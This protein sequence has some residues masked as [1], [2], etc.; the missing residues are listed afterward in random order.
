MGLPK[1]HKYHKWDWKPRHSVQFG[2]GTTLHNFSFHQKHAVKT[3]V[4][5]FCKEKIW[6]I[7]DRKFKI[8]SNTC[9]ITASAC[10]ED[11]LVCRYVLC[12]YSLEELWVIF[13]IRFLTA[14][15]VHQCQRE[16]FVHSPLRKNVGSVYVFTIHAHNVIFL[17][18]EE[19]FLIFLVFFLMGGD[20]P[21]TS[22]VLFSVVQLI[23]VSLHTACSY[24]I[25][26]VCYVQII[27]I[28]QNYFTKE[29]S[30]NLESNVKLNWLTEYCSCAV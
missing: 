19:K 21:F 5:L 9:P 22:D 15:W 3:L 27:K 23:C 1:P 2:L 10:S 26:A 8:C 11:F 25:K 16:I 4:K 20:F 13:Y 18:W 24:P 17:S 7:T 28:I 6:D 29:W 12:V 14:K 30:N